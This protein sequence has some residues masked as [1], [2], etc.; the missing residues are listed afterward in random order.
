[1]SD[2]FK[3]S[4]ICWHSLLDFPVTDIFCN[5]GLQNRYLTQ[6]AKVKLTHSLPVKAFSESVQNWFLERNLELLPSMVF[7]RG[8]KSVNTALHVD[9]AG[10]VLDEDSYTNLDSLV[11]CN[12]GI[13]IEISGKGVMKF[14]KVSSEGAKFCLTEAKTPFI[15]WPTTTVP[16]LIDETMFTEG[17]C[18]VKTNIPH[19]VD[20]LEFPRVLVS[21]R[22]AEK[23]YS[24]T[25]TWERSLELLK[26]DLIKREILV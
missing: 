19:S 25:A 2:N 5:R 24:K 10:P 8:N 6:T 14:W 11:Y 3:P 4:E 16:V 12:V 7:Y 21:L 17:P 22:F 13:N 1:M 23:G 15:K 26:N 18:L 20:G 9:L